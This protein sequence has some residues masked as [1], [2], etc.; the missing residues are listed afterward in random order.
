MV[1]HMCGVLWGSAAHL[2]VHVDIVPLLLASWTDW[3]F[4]LI[5]ASVI[6]WQQG[7]LRSCIGSTWVPGTVH[8]LEL[9]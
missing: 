1:M 9:L 6:E 4:F 7:V 3:H 5:Q 2:V 8:L